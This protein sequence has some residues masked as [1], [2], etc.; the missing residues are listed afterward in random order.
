MNMHTTIP[1]AGPILFVDD[2]SR[3]A[4]K[5]KPI[6]VVLPFAKRIDAA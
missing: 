5:S 3:V 2:L 6:D 4:L 1:P